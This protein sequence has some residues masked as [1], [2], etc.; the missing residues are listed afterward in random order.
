MLST[1]PATATSI[2]PVAILPAALII[3]IKPEAHCLSTDIP[4]TVVGKPARIAPCLA[5]F[6][7]VEPCCNAAP[8]ITSSISSFS[9]PALST[10][11][12]ITCPV[13]V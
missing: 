6:I 7:C 13:R 12:D 4:G 8:I 9:S 11:C 1:P 10:A 3:A 2:S 5:I